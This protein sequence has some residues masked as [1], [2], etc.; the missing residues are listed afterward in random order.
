MAGR[1]WGGVIGN[2]SVTLSLPPHPLSFPS[3]TEESIRETKLSPTKFPI[4]FQPAQ[5]SRNPFTHL[6]AAGVP[7]LILFMT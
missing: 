1:G 7:V 3:S 6:P 2:P 4:N 5:I